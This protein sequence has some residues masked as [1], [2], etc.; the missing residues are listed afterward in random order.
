MPGKKQ[1]SLFVRNV[2]GASVLM[3]AVSCSMGAYEEP[4]ETCGTI[5]LKY[6]LFAFNFMFWVSL[7][8]G[9][10]SVLLQRLQSGGVRSADCLKT[11]L[12]RRLS[13]LRP[14][15]GD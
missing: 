4:K 5:C 1:L 7:H 6:L 15:A 8:C 13:L 10:V 11:L 3:S 2:S 12:T 14:E 9:W